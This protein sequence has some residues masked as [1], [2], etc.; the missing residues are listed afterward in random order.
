MHDI[1]ILGQGALALFAARKVL[2]K[3]EKALVIG[4]GVPFDRFLLLHENAL[5]RLERVYG[6]A[7]GHPLTGVKVLNRHLEP[8]KFLSFADY[9]L[10][11]HAMRYSALLEWMRP[12]HEAEAITAR[13]ASLDG[14]GRVR[15]ADGRTFSARKMVINTIAAFNRP[16]LRFRHRKV[17]RMRFLQT[18][19]AQD[20]VLQINDAG[21]YAAI[22]PFGDEAAVVSSGD[23]TP[24]RALLGESVMKTP[25]MELHLETWCGL[26]MRQGRVVHVGEAF[27]R[28]HPHTGQ[29]LNRALDTID[30]LLEGRGLA[31]ERIYD[32]LMWAGGIALDLSWG[33]SPF[34]RDAI[35]SLLDTRIGMRLLS[36]TAFWPD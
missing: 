4:E 1:I 34:L 23:E 9:G 8:L 32:C 27:R 7:P 35:F 21:C 29:G 2:M 13:V 14:E 31:R 12:W 18:D 19:V 25:V 20:A 5:R 28:V 15:L 11:L 33:V 10:R 36:G 30:A 17:F 6:S 3:G 22:V 26:I 16:R 24:L